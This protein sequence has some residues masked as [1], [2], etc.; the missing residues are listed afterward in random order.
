MLGG[1]YWK[2]YF[3]QILPPGSNGV[4]VILQ[5]TCGQAF[6]YQVDG[7]EARFV[8]HGDLHNPK[9]DHLCQDSHEFDSIFEDAFDDA[10]F[11]PS[12]SSSSVGATE[13][14]CRYSLQA[15]PSEIFEQRFQTNRPFLYVLS[16]AGVF[17]FTSAFLILYDY[18]VER[19]QR[20]V[21]K[22]AQRSGAIVRSLFPDDV[23]DRLYEEQ[24]AEKSRREMVP[25]RNSF[26][27]NLSSTAALTDGT[28]GS[29]GVIAKLYPDCTVFF[30]GKF[31]A[32]DVYAWHPFM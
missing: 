29:P 8:G 26:Q 18:C 24:D 11:S 5:N 17:A 14:E 31:H 7:R 13:G 28:N 10:S 3:R 25:H 22:S 19:R 12:S 4:L 30:A 20:L 1:V 32:I 6:T 2:T 23:R 21:L 15:Y 9:Y 27:D 16:L